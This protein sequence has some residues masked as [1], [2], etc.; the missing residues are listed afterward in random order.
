MVTLKNNIKSV[1]H[2]EM[3]EVLDRIGKE[4]LDEV[5]LHSQL[6][7]DDCLLA[8]KE[9]LVPHNLVHNIETFIPAFF[10]L[11]AGL[12]TD[13]YKQNYLTLISGNFEKIN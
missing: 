10:L 3:V 11:R 2:R 13:L 4:L 9:L 6:K 7:V 5:R 12:H 8:I 1:S